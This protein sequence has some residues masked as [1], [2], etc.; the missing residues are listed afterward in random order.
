MVRPALEQVLLTVTSTPPL[1]QVSELERH[2]QLVMHHMLPEHPL[3]AIESWL[4][5]NAWNRRM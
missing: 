3:I 5:F 1:E 2:M 4:D